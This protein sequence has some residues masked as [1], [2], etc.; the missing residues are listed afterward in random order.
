MYR[1]AKSINWV[2]FR[3]ALVAIMFALGTVVLMARAYQLHVSDAE[4]LKKRADRQRTRVLRLEARRGMILDRSGE[5]LAASLEVRSI[6]ARPHRIKD[7]PR[8]AGILAE[9]LGVDKQKIIKK[10]EDRRHFAWIRRR[11]SPLLA[12]KVKAAHLEGVFEVTE[13]RRFYPLKSLAAHATGFAGIDSRGLEGLEL[14]YD[15]DL[16]SDPIPVTA[17]R[18]ALGRPSMFAAQEQGPGRRDLHVT[19]DRNI[20]YVVEKELG[21]AVRKERA[22]GGVVVIMAADSG[23]ILA[24]AVRPTYNLNVFGKAPARARRNRAIADAFEP[25]STFKVFLAAAALDLGKTQLTESYYCHKGVYEYRGTKIHDTAPRKWLTFEQILV[26][27]SNIGAVKIAEKLTK[28]EFYRFLKGF[29]FGSP[30]GV[31]LPGERSGLLAPPG[32]WSGLTKANIGFGQGITVNALQLTAA[33]AAIVN[34]GKLVRPHLI[35]RMSAAM[36]E[37]VREY[38]PVAVR[39]VVK[40]STSAKMVRMLRKV[41][42]K[43]TGKRAH[44]PGV[45]LIGKTGTAQ[46]A[47]PSGGYSRK[48]Y[49]AS[50]LGALMGSRPRLAIFVMIDEPGGRHK[51]GGRVAAPLFRK[52]ARGVL[53]HCGGR[54]HSEG[55][56]LASLRQKWKGPARSAR[57]K[58]TLKRGARPGEWIVPDLRGLSMRRVLE[59]C[60]KM[61]CDISFRGVGKAVRQEPAP[62]ALLKEGAP[63]TVFFEGKRS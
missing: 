29:G 14:Y 46:K 53:A 7:K 58:I 4:K 57:K 51:T 55:L 33:F 1:D 52:I 13:Y 11:V 26:H 43:G 18:D 30:T 37:T 27:S 16:K 32:K 34:G 22:R 15:K 47:D 28:S 61:K 39:K 23:E 10:L 12:E 8:A 19:L 20:Q 50:F 41:V 5:P 48:K 42:L 44:I 62:G 45:E 25:G 6:Y 56:V 21:D 24:L 40:S 9:I 17:Q 49:V 2:S 63:M 31:D 38:R 59:I 60:G 3:I 54:P 36:G 35:K